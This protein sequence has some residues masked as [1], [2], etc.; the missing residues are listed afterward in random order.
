MKKTI[1]LITA[2]ITLFSLT[3]CT[4]KALSPQETK[5]TKMSYE[6]FLYNFLEHEVLLRKE[7]GVKHRLKNAH[8]PYKKY[9]EDFCP[10][11]TLQ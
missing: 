7:N 5:V 9:L 2:I 3:S 8:F 10:N 6:D 4:D 11:L 1:S